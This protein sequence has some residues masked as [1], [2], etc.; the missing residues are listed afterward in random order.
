MTLNTQ[1]GL[2]L[3]TVCQSQVTPLEE[4]PCSGIFSV[5]VETDTHPAKLPE[6]THIRARKEAT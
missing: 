1:P 5:G 6:A 4:N 3:V 2:R